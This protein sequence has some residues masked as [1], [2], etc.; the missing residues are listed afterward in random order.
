MLFGVRAYCKRDAAGVAFT[1][2][3]RAHT[4]SSCYGSEV[5]RRESRQCQRGDH[6]SRQVQVA[7]GAAAPIPQDGSLVAPGPFGKCIPAH[8]HYDTTTLARA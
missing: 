1:E 7:D 3:A 5:S 6:P 8:L 2:D 4:Q